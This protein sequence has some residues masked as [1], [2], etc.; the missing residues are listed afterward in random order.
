MHFYDGVTGEPRYEVPYADGRPGTRSPTIADC[1]KHGWVPGVTSVLGILDKPGLNNWKVEQAILAALTCPAEKTRGLFNEELVN[2]VKRDAE[3][4]S[5]VAMQRGTDI[6]DAIEKLWIDDSTGRFSPYREHAEATLSLVA[7]QYPAGEVEWN[8]EAHLPGGLGYGGRCD[9]YNDEFVIDFK[10]K[11]FGP[12]DK[13][14]GWPEQEVQLVA[15]DLGFGGPRRRLVNVFV[16]A[17][18]PGLVRWFEWPEK[19][20][21]AA[22]KKWFATLACWQAWKGYYPGEMK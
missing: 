6:H 19:G 12:D 21:D 15:Y 13:I 18:V 22:V 8:V 11:E 17:S 1:R 20:Y 7:S 14:Q 16:S 3:E 9:L 2:V 10:T 5:K 4:Q